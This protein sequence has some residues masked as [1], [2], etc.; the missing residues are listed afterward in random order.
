MFEVTNVAVENNA[1]R[2]FLPIG[3]FITGGER[4]KKQRWRTE[5]RSVFAKS[6]GEIHCI[7]ATRQK[8]MMNTTA[9]ARS[10]DGDEENI[11]KRIDNDE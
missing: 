8:K 3:C 11:S 6:V 10:G 9:D 4:I 2:R 1:I 7:V 5:R